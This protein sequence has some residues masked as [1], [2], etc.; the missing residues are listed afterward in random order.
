M[1][2]V[3]RPVTQVAVVAVNKASIKGIALP[4]AELIGSVKRILPITKQNN[5]GS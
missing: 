2:K 3:T 1:G 4:F 5:L